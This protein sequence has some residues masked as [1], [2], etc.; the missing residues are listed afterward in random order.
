MNMAT[1]KRT[2]DGTMRNGKLDEALDYFRAMPVSAEQGMM[3][4]QFETGG[5]T[6]SFKRGDT[7]THV[8]DKLEGTAERLRKYQREGWPMYV[9][10]GH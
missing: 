9:S 3:A 1:E 2:N 7:M 10:P 8:A 6:I 4:F 5:F